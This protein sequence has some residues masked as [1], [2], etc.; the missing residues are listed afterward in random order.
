MGRRRGYGGVEGEGKCN[1]GSTHSRGVVHVQN[2]RQGPSLALA[3]REW[4]E[5]GEA[6]A[7]PRKQT[8]L[9]DRVGAGVEVAWW[10]SQRAHARVSWHPR[11]R[12]DMGT[13]AGSWQV[14]AGPIFCPLSHLLNDVHWCGMS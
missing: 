4:V 11:I 6:D 3:P 5:R 2:A 12:S 7:A 1:V 9:R 14:W 13:D 10:G 8:P